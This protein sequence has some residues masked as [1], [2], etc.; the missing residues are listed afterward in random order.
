MP[1]NIYLYYCKYGYFIFSLYGCYYCAFSCNIY[2]FGYMGS[3]LAI[4][5]RV[6]VIA[7]WLLAWRHTKLNLN[8]NYEHLKKPQ[9]KDNFHKYSSR[10]A[11][12]SVYLCV[13]A[14]VYA[15]FLRQLSAFWLATKPTQAQPSI[16]P[17]ILT[18]VGFR[19]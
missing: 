7:L 8:I 15:I 4:K 5:Q 6:V 10:A 13:C 17:T 18:P 16:E 12:V 3:P 19:S 14:C 2:L 1:L 11:M 9:R